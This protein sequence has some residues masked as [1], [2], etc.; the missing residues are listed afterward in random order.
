MKN[1]ICFED[2]FSI[3][4]LASNF[5]SKIHAINYEQDEEKTYKD[6]LMSEYVHLYSKSKAMPNST[7]KPNTTIPMLC[8]TQPRMKKIMHRDIR[9][10]QL[11]NIPTLESH[12]PNMQLQK[13]NKNILMQVPYYPWLEWWT[14]MAWADRFV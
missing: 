1:L 9:R 5:L 3:L 13:A 12:S 8:Y 11:Q 2:W 6:N 14:Q 7:L 10:R 4:N